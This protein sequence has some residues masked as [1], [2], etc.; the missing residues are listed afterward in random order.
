MVSYKE[1]QKQI[2]QELGRY[3]IDPAALLPPKQREAVELA[4]QIL[5][6]AP[7]HQN[8]DLSKDDKSRLTL[9]KEKLQGESSSGLES[10]LE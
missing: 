4:N 1:A 5:L 3:E 10:F 7:S 6:K 2:Y 9:F 8:K